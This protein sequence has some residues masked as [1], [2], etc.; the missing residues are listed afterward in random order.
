MKILFRILLLLAI[1]LSIRFLPSAFT[2][3]L[4][5]TSEPESWQGGV[6]GDSTIIWFAIIIV[7]YG[8]LSM[9]TLL[10]IFGLLF[11]FNGRKA[12]F[13]L[14]VLPGIFGFLLGLL[15]LVLLM[16]YDIEWPDSWFVAVVLV[17]PPFVALF[18]GIVSR[19][20]TLKKVKLTI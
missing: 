18:S 17:V 2:A 9:Q 11:G 8:Y 13:W 20:R 14:L 15:W 4:T 1:L 3:F 16:I 5:I 6:D 10:A 12:A 7:G 19:V